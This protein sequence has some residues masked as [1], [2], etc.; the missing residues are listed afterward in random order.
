MA[1]RGLYVF[2]HD[3]ALGRAPAHQLFE[4]IQIAPPSGVARGFADFSVTVN[5]AELPEGVELVMLV[6]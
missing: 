1:T 6:G 3:N 4:R 5:S 2:K